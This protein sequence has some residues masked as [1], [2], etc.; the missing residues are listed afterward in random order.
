MRRRLTH[1]LLVAGVGLSL[2]C[3]ARDVPADA[4]RRRLDLLKTSEQGAAALP[5]LRQGL[6]DE[7]AV[8]RRTAARLLGELGAPATEALQEAWKSDDAVVR[9][10]ALKA[11]VHLEGAERDAV[12]GTALADADLTVRM[13]AAGALAALPRSEATQALL[14]TAAKDSSDAVRAIASRALWPFRRDVTPL[15]ERPDWDHEVAVIQAIPLP[16]DDWRFAL[17][18]MRDGH[19]SKWFEAAFDDSAWKTLA[20]EQTWEKAGHTY[21]GVAWYR[22]TVELPAKPEGKINA[23]EIAFEAVDECAWVWVNGTYVGRHDLG[24][25]GWDK[26]FT[27]DISDA[28]RW[29]APNQITVRV[30]DTAYAGG[31]WKPVRIEALR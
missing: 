28:V 8:V 31:I 9:Q 26:A 13:L 18:P 3:A 5:A 12:L 23:V 21:D 20:I 22:R 25:A 19:L 24:T 15:R 16:K 4:A 6:A 1:G 14:Q 7:N 17:D 30:L 29:G 11:L 27:L 10:T 2:L